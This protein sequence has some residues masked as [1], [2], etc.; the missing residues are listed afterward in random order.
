MGPSRRRSENRDGAGTLDFCPTIS[1][2]EQKIA[3]VSPWQR[4][5]NLGFGIVFDRQV[6]PRV[7]DQVELAPQQTLAKVL[8][9]NSLLRHLPERI[10][11]VFVSE[12]FAEGIIDFEVWVRS[13]QRFANLQCLNPRQLAATRRN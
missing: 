7:H 1:A 8:R 6:L 11:L 13:P 4:D 12:G 3:R 9:E 2:D 5:G 10:V